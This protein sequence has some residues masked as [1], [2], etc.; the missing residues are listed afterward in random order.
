MA[1]VSDRAH[2]GY[3]LEVFDTSESQQSLASRFF[4]RHAEFDVAP[5]RFL[6]VM[7]HLVSALPVHF[8]ASKQG[9]KPGFWVKCERLL[10]PNDRQWICAQS[11][12]CRRD[13]RRKAYEQ[14]AHAGQ[15]IAAEIETAG[16][17][18]EAL[19]C[20]AENQCPGQSKRQTGDCSRFNAA[21]NKP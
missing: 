12:N 19:Q 1:P 15:K 4:S 9:G 7:A 3:P 17:E 20:P 21:D 11:T 14:Q 6:Q 2:R 16:A 5:N 13:C 18:E 8:A 10:Y